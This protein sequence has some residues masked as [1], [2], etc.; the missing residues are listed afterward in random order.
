MQNT[1][2]G[3]SS[4][5]SITGAA[6]GEPLRPEHVS[7]VVRHYIGRV[8]EQAPHARAAVLL[9]KVDAGPSPSEHE[10]E[11]HLRALPLAAVVAATQRGETRRWRLG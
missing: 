4:S 5:A 10:L 1:F 11:Q 8:R 6:A 3:P 2:T 9:N 7:A